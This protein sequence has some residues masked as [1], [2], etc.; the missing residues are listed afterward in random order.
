MIQIAGIYGWGDEN[1]YL[2]DLNSEASI[3]VKNTTLYGL[4]DYRN[5]QNFPVNNYTQYSKNIMPENVKILKL[6]EYKIYN[7][8]FGEL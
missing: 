6:K 3:S 1:V 7:E 2:I 8:D 5:D 4:S